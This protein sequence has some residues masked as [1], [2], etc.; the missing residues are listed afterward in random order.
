VTNG[1]LSTRCEPRDWR[2]TSSDDLAARAGAGLGF[3]MALRTSG[4]DVS[5]ELREFVD[6]YIAA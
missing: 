5:T 3:A 6:R 4:P 2:T 1:L